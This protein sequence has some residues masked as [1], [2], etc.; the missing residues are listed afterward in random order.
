MVFY[1][2]LYVVHCYICYAFDTGRSYFFIN[3]VYKEIVIQCLKW[4]SDTQK[5]FYSAY[6]NLMKD[7]QG[8]GGEHLALVTFF[9]LL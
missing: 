4:Q 1:D 9:L 7:R 6:T 5:S 3:I 2:I 8:T